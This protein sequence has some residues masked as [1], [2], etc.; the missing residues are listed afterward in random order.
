MGA[1]MALVFYAAVRGGF[2]AITGGANVRASDLSPY[3]VTA[4]AALVG[5]FSNQ[6][7]QKL[8]DIFDVLF[9]PSSGKELKNPL[10]GTTPATPS[11]GTT[12]A[13][14]SGSSTAATQAGSAPAAQ[15]K[16]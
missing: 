15:T 11:G 1:I 12:S 9:K 5:M 13:S 2:L 3:G 4:I 16:T 7:T 8:A 14:S 6:A 10:D